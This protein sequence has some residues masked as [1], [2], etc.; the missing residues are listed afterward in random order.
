MEKK[1]ERVWFFNDCEKNETNTHARQENPDQKTLMN[2]I[3]E[4]RASVKHWGFTTAESFSFIVLLTRHA[5]HSE[6]GRVTVNK[7]MLSFRIMCLS[8][9][10]PTLVCSQNPSEKRN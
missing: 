9:V 5:G 8:S 7:A 1:Q 4:Q 6:R 3:V 2:D 10:I